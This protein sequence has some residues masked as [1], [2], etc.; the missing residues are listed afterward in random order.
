MSEFCSHSH[1]SPR[2]TKVALV[3]GPATLATVPDTVPDEDTERLCAS[4]DSGQRSI[5]SMAEYLILM[6]GLLFANRG[7]CSSNILNHFLGQ[8]RCGGEGCRSVVVYRAFH[9][10][11]QLMV[12]IHL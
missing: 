5:A 7:T 11:Q 6:S 4:I 9:C 3:P 1:C 2:Y 8:Q 12:G 10:D